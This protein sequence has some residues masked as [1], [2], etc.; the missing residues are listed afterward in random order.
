MLVKHFGLIEDQLLSKSKIQQ[1]TGHPL[2]KGNPREAF[3]HKF[4]KVLLSERYGIG[5]GE[6][7]DFDSKPGDKRNQIDI[8]IY[9]NDHPRLDFGGEIIG[10]LAESVVATI[11][12]KS[13]LTEAELRKSIKSSANTKKLKKNLVRS[14][15]SGN[16]PPNIL[17]YVVAYA[18]P[19][20]IK[21]VHGWINK[22]H[23]T[24]GISDFNLPTDINDRLNV[25]SPSIDGVFIL[26][27]GF[28]YLDNVPVVFGPAGKE[29][30]ENEPTVKWVMSNIPSGTLMLLF[31]FLTIAISG[32]SFDS[33]D[34]FP[35]LKS[36]DIDN[37]AFSS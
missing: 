16:E 6:I 4:L 29:I 35:Y 3:I 26:G 8:V 7:I 12:V 20:N 9:R 36:F 22:S 30:R 31:L 21:T 34:P 11:E 25:S 13:K 2:H 5:T 15:S 10:F 23:K 33:L 19:K 24:L 14:L 1:S 28:I 37:I 27:N 18:G 32:R 17:S